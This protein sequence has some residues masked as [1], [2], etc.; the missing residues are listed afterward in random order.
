MKAEYI[1]LDKSIQPAM[2]FVHSSLE[3]KIITYSCKTTNRT[4]VNKARRSLTVWTDRGDTP[5]VAVAQ[6]IRSVAGPLPRRPEFK[7]RPVHAE[8]LRQVCLRILC[9]S[10]CHY[11]FTNAPYSSFISL[12]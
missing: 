4:A 9:S 3:N 6:I 7:H 8:A 12:L 11:H 1:N 2:Q 10:C 5:P